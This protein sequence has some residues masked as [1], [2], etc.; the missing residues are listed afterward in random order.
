MQG[1]ASIMDYGE[2]FYNQLV[3]KQR[4]LKLKE[5]NWVTNERE[6]IRHENEFFVKK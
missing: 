5:V 1:S 4:Y 6:I 2:F 3:G